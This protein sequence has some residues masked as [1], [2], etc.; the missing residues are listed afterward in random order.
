VWL[1]QYMDVTPRGVS[2]WCTSAAG[3]LHEQLAPL[4]WYYWGA[5]VSG[6]WG[7]GAPP[8]Y[9]CLCAA[10]HHQHQQQLQQQQQVVS[11]IRHQAQILLSNLMTDLMMN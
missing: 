3:P 8:G 1:F 10:H 4:D 2:S 9:C 5:A 6:H 11:G 7:G